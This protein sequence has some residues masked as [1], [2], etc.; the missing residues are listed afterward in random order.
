MD[1]YCNSKDADKE[2]KNTPEFGPTGTPST[3]KKDES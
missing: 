2:Y 3:E 1:K